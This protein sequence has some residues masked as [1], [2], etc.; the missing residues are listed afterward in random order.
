MELTVTYILSQVFTILMYALL[1]VTYY[2]KNRKT[3][4]VI[5]FLSLIAN[6]M[7]YVLL[8]AYTGL[9]MCVI[10]LLRNIIFLVDEKKNYYDLYVFSL[11]EK[12]NR[13]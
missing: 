3:V 6:S 11:A 5:S 8:N 13:L 2:V 10:A 9:A 7:A 1:V 4:L 12:N